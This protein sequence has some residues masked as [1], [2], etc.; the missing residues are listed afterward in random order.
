MTFVY[1]EGSRFVNDAR[2]GPFRRVHQC[3][4]L[5]ALGSRA[6][7]YFFLAVFDFFAG[8]VVVLVKSVN[9]TGGNGTTS[10]GFGGGGDIPSDDGSPSPRR[11]GFSRPAR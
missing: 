4:E 3:N 2:N 5:F 6:P 9:V 1:I 7:N 11:G 8:A 10:C